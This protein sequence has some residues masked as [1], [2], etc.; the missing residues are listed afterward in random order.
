[1]WIMKG[2]KVDRDFLNSFMNECLKNGIS[3]S[4]DMALA[5]K[6]KIEI[7]D[8][9]IR[10][11]EELKTLRCKLLDVVFSFEKAEKQISKEEQEA[12]LFHKINNS[13]ISKSI[14]KL[15]IEFN[16]ELPLKELEGRIKKSKHDIYFCVKQMIDIDVC[17]RD[18]N[19][20]SK[21]KLFDEYFSF[22]GKR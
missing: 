9:R 11:I 14:C 3:S 8:Y 20:L 19:N 10:E 13:A 5:A 12:L 15:L 7:I 4:Q 17:Y 21:G 2:K 6:N 1:M 18:G 22:V 16:N